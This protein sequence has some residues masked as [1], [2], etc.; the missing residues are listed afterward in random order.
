MSGDG[1]VGTEETFTKTYPPI[2]YIDFWRCPLGQTAVQCIAIESVIQQ[3]LPG[4]SMLELKPFFPD[5][6]GK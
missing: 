6:L 5:P 4:K 3:E 2:P 1:G